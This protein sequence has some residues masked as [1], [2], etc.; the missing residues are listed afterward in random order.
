MSVY[1]SS[2]LSQSRQM[3]L[4]PAAAFCFCAVPGSSRSPSPE[5]GEVSSGGSTLAD[6][7]EDISNTADWA[8]AVEQRVGMTEGVDALLFQE[9]VGVFGARVHLWGP[10]ARHWA[11]RPHAAEC[12]LQ[13]SWTLLC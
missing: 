9:R 4:L 10:R 2:S 13:N 6:V 8:R 5:G 1:Y 11:A 12:A 3:C 7:D